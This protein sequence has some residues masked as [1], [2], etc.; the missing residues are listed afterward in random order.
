MAND[1]LPFA[2]QSG[3]NVASQGDYAALVARL[4]GFSAGIANSAQLN[5]AWRQSSVIA[6]I[7]GQFIENHA[8]LDALDNGNLA[9]LL[10]NFEAAI[11]RQDLNYVGTVGGSANALTANLDPAPVSNTA[12]TTTPLRL[13]IGAATNTGPA[14]LALNGLAA[15][16]ILTMRGQQL[17]RGDLPAGAV[18]SV[19]STGTAYVLVGVTYSE[20]RVRLTSTL[21]VYVRTDGN[22]NNDGSANTSGSAFATIQG[23]LNRIRSL[24]DPVG[25]SVVI[26][27][28]VAGTY[29]GNVSIPDMGSPIVIEGDQANQDAYIITGTGAAGSAL[30]SFSGGDVAIQGVAITNA[31]TIA[32]SLGAVIGARVIVSNTTFGS[33]APFSAFAHISSSL[34]ASVLVN[35]GVR[36]AGDMS[37]TFLATS[38]GTITALPSVGV[39]YVGSRTMYAA[40][41]AAQTGSIVLSAGVGFGGGSVAGNRYTVNLNG[42]INTN[43]AGPNI[44]PGSVAG[45]NSTGGQYV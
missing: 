23:A 26:K 6:A 31:G 39:T 19:I 20:F 4:S 17:G 33:T 24:Y 25:N 34:G 2:T 5:K 42:V 7:I 27:L 32:H 18:V 35:H 28:G 10:A 37:Y 12:L 45:S 22:D 44:F 14:T 36:I 43:G 21:T 9:A 29:N 30:L 15:L 11:R 38:Y 13:Q 40:T 41:A 3:A 1:F 16:P 8:Q